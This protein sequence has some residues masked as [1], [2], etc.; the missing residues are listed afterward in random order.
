[1]LTIE[2]GIELGIIFR[3]MMMKKFYTDNALLASQ[4]CSQ[5]QQ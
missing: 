4:F 3:T 1:V 5:Q 2:L